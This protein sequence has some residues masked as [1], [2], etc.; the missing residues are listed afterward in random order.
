MDP[1]LEIDRPPDP[2]LKRRFALRGVDEARTEVVR[3]QRAP[4]DC[5]LRNHNLKKSFRKREV[6]LGEHFIVER[7]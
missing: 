2:I 4:V 7:F 6:S 5:V 3:V 1:I